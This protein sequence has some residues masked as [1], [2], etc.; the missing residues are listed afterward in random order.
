MTPTAIPLPPYYDPNGPASPA[1]E[2]AQELTEEEKA[3]ISESNPELAARAE[4][5]GKKDKEAAS[6]DDSGDYEEAYAE[7]DG[8]K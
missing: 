6:T 2:K 4:A 3:I 5:A 1:E 7:D 8:E